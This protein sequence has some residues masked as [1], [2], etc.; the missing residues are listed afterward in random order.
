MPNVYLQYVRLQFEVTTSYVSSMQVIRSNTPV[1]PPHAHPLASVLHWMMTFSGLTAQN[2]AEL[3]VLYTKYSGRG[4]EILGFPCNQFGSQEP[5]T[6]AEV[7]VLST[8]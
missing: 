5:G 3:A 2:Y 6:N 7:Q 8:L 1:C 4:L